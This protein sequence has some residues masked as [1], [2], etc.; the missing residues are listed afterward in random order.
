M[1]QFNDTLTLKLHKAPDSQE[2]DASERGARN[3]ERDMQEEL[4]RSRRTSL[5]KKR[6][7]GEKKGGEREGE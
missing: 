7:D 6:R 3:G 2:K 1:P 5:R 4:L